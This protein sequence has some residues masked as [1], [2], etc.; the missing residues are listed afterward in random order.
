MDT[1]KTPN[2]QSNLE[3]EKW[4]W[5]N[6]LWSS[7]QY[8]TGTTRQIN[9]SIWSRIESPEINPHNYNQVVYNKEGRTIMEKN[10]SASGAGRAGQ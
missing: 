10:S 2:N 4:S 6:Q 5:K 1:Q 9:Q 8:G 3:K 7:K